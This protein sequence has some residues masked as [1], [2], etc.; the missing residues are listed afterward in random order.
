MNNMTSLL[1]NHTEYLELATFKASNIHSTLEKAADSA[2]SWNQNFEWGGSIG[3]YALRIITPLTTLILGNYG[4]PPSFARNAALLLGGKIPL[5]L[6]I[7]GQVNV[8]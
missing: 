5:H 8:S 7:E 3:I 1:Q 4:L 2:G 6:Y